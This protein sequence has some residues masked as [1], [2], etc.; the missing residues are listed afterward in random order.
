MKTTISARETGGNNK[1]SVLM[2]IV[3]PI[4]KKIITPDKNSFL[5]VCKILDAA[6]VEIFVEGRKV[7]NIKPEIIPDD[8]EE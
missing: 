7:K 2:C 5:Q 4:D 1:K 6:K 8:A 3:S